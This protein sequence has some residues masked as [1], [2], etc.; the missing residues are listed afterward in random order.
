MATPSICAIKTERGDALAE[1]LCDHPE[2]EWLYGIGNLL[3][4]S[5]QIPLHDLTQQRLRSANH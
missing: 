3:A 4:T 1:W 2:R 5:Y